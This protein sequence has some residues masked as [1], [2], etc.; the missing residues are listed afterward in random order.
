MVCP[1]S[2]QRPDFR[3]CLVSVETALR[4]STRDATDPR[5]VTTA[6]PGH[7]GPPVFAL[8]LAMA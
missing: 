7:A 2:R 3:V 8:V 4:D 5:K 6:S 1:L